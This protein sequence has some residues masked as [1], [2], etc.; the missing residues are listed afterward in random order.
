[1][2]AVIARIILRYRAVFVWLILAFTYFMY[3]QSD[4]VRLSYEMARL[5]PHDS[6]TQLDYNYFVKKF[7]ESD[8]LMFVGVD[9]D[10]FFVYQKFNYWQK[11]SENL[12]TIEG[13]NSVFSIVDA[14]ALNKNE[15]EKKFE[16]FKLFD[17]VKNQS[18]LDASH[19]KV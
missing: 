15:Q 13:V 10:S 8:N 1:M 12:K 16:S 3:Q 18:D 7:G 14:I 5:L 6:E 19:L 9:V 4:K 11:F 2:W 17:N